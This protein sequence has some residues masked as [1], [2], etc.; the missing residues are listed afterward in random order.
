MEAQRRRR[1]GQGRDV[2]VEDE[3]D[4]GEAEEERDT[5]EAE[6]ERGIEFVVAVFL[7]TKL[8]KC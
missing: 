2:A 4:T 6:D 1:K 3:R 7:S 5:G 8:R